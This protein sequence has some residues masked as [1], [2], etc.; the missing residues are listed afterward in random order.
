MHRIVLTSRGESL[1]EY[2]SKVYQYRSL[3]FTLARKDLKVQYAQTFLGVLWSVIQ[4]LTSLL[5]WI[6]FFDKLIKVDTG[7]IPYPLFAFSGMMGWYYFTNIFNHAGTSLVNSQDLIRKIYFP[8]IILPLSKV[9]V[10]FVEFFISLTLLF[11]MML[12]MGKFPSWHILFLPVFILLNII[13]GLA[14]GLW[15]SALTIRYRDFQHIIPF[16][17]YIGIWLTPV[18]YPSTL[19]PSEYSFYIYINPVAAVIAGYRWSLLGGEPFSPYYLISFIPML[20]I[21]LTGFV[22][23]RKSEYTI[24]DYI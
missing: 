12:V 9:M 4:P 5:V 11:I 20:F 3:A 8:R 24:A 2:T 10:G 7:D 21:L 16:F 6:L 1:K 13:S 22:Y 15:L 14:F 23:F 17:V 18:F 19:I